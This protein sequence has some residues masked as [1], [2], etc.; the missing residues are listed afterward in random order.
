MALIATS[1]STIEYLDRKL[2][3]DRRPYEKFRKLI[4]F[5]NKKENYVLELAFISQYANFENFMFSLT[6]ELLLRYPSSLKTEKTLKFEDVCSCKN[7][8][9]VKRY[10]AN[11]VAIEKSYDLNTWSQ[12]LD[13]I[14]GIKVF[15]DKKEKM[16][17]T[18]LNIIRNSILHGGKKAN[19][20][21]VNDFNKYLKV[22]VKIGEKIEFDKRYYEMIFILSKKIISNIQKRN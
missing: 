13:D 19:S 14:F 17:L 21:T 6:K 16:F 2:S 4:E 9:E 3:V 11:V 20:K 8:S 10:F 22:K 18:L 12:F 7:I 5:D 15:A 1:K